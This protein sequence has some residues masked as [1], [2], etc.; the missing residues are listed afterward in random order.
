M[1]PPGCQARLEEYPPAV[2]FRVSSLLAASCLLALAACGAPKSEG[3]A[4][5]SEDASVVAA[6]QAPHAEPGPAS[7]EAA[8]P[9]GAAADEALGDDAAAAEPP[10]IDHE[11]K[12]IAGETVS[13]T[14]YR[15]KALLIVNTASQCGYTPQYA[16]LQKLYGKY[17]DQG[18]VVLG[19]P[20]NDYG[21]QE[22]GT[23]DEIAS[24]V[25]DEFGVEFPMMDKVH[26]KGP[27]K[28]PLYVAL[29]ERTPEGIRGEVKWNFTKFL[30]DPEGKVVARFDTPVDP[31]A[32]E[33][34]QAIEAVLPDA[35]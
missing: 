29:T 5:K 30:I 31:L 10:L 21:G 12:N 22:P 27:D 11:V 33:V 19:F 35:G 14:D 16:N 23:N 3:E 15:G 28:A 8:T 32:P 9:A 1:R 25:D 26:T 20:S 17:K 24:F 2:P 18:L 13:L 6:D 4:A 34:T 7:D